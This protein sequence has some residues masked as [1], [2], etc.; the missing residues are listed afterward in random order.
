M[1]CDEHHTPIVWYGVFVRKKL[2]EEKKT[3]EKGS[4]VLQVPYF[5]RTIWSALY[6]LS[7]SET[8][9]WISVLTIRVGHRRTWSLKLEVLEGISWVRVVY[10][11]VVCYLAVWGYIS[12][13]WHTWIQ[14]PSITDRLAMS[15]PPNKE[16]SPRKWLKQKFRSVFS[17]S[18]SR[19]A[20]WKCDPQA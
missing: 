5:S 16:R 18:R 17:S 19:A 15:T 4:T 13:Y 9:K 8:W 6:E 20:T 12:K 7:L 1:H 10:Y 11:I 14:V 3:N 2:E